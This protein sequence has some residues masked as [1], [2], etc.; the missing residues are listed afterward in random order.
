[1]FLGTRVEANWDSVQYTKVKVV[2]MLD[3][4]HSMD[5]E[6]ADVLVTPE[7]IYL[8]HAGVV[9]VIPRESVEFMTVARSTDD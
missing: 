9:D 6:R 4:G 5:I 1:M 7:W 2:M 8:E 3:T